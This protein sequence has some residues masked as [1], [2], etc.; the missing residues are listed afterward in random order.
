[1]YRYGKSLREVGLR[2][3]T[4]R[5]RTADG[6]LAERRLTTWRTHR[7][8]VVASKGGKWIVFAM[9]DR[10]LSALQQ[11]FLRTKAKDLQSFLD[12]ARLQAN[13]SNNT[14]FAD[15]SGAIAYLHPQF[16]PRRSARFDYR[17]PVPLDPASDWGALHD[18]SELPNAVR[19]AN[20]WVQNT[21]S[22][23]YRAAGPFSPDPK[24]Y[25][26]YMDSFGEN[27][28]ERHALQLLEGSGD[29]TLDRLQ[30]AAYDSYQ[31]GFAVLV[32]QLIAAFDRLP[33][34]DPRRV[35]LAAPIAVLRGWDFRWHGDSVAQ[36][37]AMSWGESLRK[38]LAPPAG[39]PGNVSMMRIGRDTS[40]EQKLQAF[41]DAVAALRRDFG[42]WQVPWAEIN[43][44]QRLP[45]TGAQAFRDDA[46]STPVPFASS[47]WGSLAAFGFDARSPTRRWYGTK[48]NSFVA[49]VEFGPRVR[50]RAISAGG[51][52]GDPASPHFNDQSARY[53]AGALREVYFYPEQLKGRTERRYRPGE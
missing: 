41:S 37:L 12:V 43:R 52:S 38:A 4:I 46:P 10:P 31:P 23:P 32:P 3:V 26:R 25:P 44:L 39:E 2:P 5:Y 40:A 48:G 1:M 30:A 14:I 29:W 45:S 22:W 6:R 16:V 36:S 21:N 51:A 11:S 28:R 47:V 7:G 13:S 33:K 27:Y 9:M 34:S 15:R 42:R 19:P 49:V 24:R 18:I 53:A 35:Q 50:A 8:P 20:G 17:K